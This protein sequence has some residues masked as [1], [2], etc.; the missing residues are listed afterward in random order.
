MVI[1][2]FR[3]CYY[4]IRREN[5]IICIVCMF[6]LDGCGLFKVE[7]KIFI[8]GGDGGLLVNGGINI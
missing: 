3:C 2:S 4:L 5:K 1:N 6:Y 7:I 8:Y